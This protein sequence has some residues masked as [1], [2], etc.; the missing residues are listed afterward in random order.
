MKTVFKILVAQFLSL[1]V[2]QAAPIVL[3]CST[4]TGQKVADL[5]IDIDRETMKWGIVEYVIVQTN[6]TYIT[7]YQKD[8]DVGGEVWVINRV[9]GSYKRAA[10]GLYYDSNYSPGDEGTFKAQTYEGNCSRQ[11]F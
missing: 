8:A 6:D 10:V 11:Q 9:S 3:Q 5:T 7:G 2:A 4:S 1:Q